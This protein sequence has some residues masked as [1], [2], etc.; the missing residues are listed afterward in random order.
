MIKGMQIETNF[1]SEKQRQYHILK[2]STIVKEVFVSISLY[3]GTTLYI[4]CL[5]SGLIL[6]LF[7]ISLYKSSCSTES[8]NADRV[9]E[10]ASP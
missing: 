7:F 1:C 10:Q 9:G 5:G 8:S 6:D 2:I 3:E 4:A